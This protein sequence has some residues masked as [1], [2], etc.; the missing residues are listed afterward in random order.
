LLARS[1]QFLYSEH[2][3][4]FS[5]ASSQLDYRII[6]DHDDGNLDAHDPF[7]NLERHVGVLT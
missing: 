2:R 5:L 6:G 1:A 7:Q 4:R 3:E